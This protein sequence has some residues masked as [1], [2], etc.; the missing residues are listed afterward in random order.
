MLNKVKEL[1]E[2]LKRA[3][4]AVTQANEEIDSV[5]QELD[6]DTLQ[7]LSGAGDPFAD[8]PRVST[9]SIDSS[10]RNRG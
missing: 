9:K 3:Q 5:M 1:K 4:D 7:E 2:R 10:L 6:D 8:R